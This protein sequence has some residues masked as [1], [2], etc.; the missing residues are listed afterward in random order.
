MHINN[1]LNG[2]QHKSQLR[3]KEFRLLLRKNKKTISCKENRLLKKLI[4]QIINSSK[5]K[6]SLGA[7]TIL[8]YNLFSFELVNF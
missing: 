6:L 5:F 3:S 4:C 8:C 1:K 7:S 2:K